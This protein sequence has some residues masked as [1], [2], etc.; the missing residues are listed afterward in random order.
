MLNY[1]INYH[2][3]WEMLCELINICIAQQKRIILLTWEDGWD[4]NWIYLLKRALM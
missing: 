4:A 1:N 2:N 3:I